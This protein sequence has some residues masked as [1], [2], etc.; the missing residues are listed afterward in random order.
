MTLVIILGVMLTAGMY[1]LADVVSTKVIE[2]HFYNEKNIEERIDGLYG[3]L[4]EYIDQN[5]VKG[6]DTKKL[7]TWTR[8]HKYAFLSIYDD[9]DTVFESGWLDE[10]QSIDDGTAAE[11]TDT[12]EDLELDLSGQVDIPIDE[13]AY[14]AED[15]KNREI[16]FADSEYYV[17]MDDYSENQWYDI[18]RTIQVVLSFLTLLLT[19]LIYSRYLTKRV[20]R[21]SKE[22]EEVSQGNL[23]KQI[24][25]KGKSMDE[26]TSLATGVEDMRRSVLEKLANEQ[27]AWDANCQLITAMSHDIRTPLTSMIGY[28]DIINGKKYESEEEF[29]KYITTCREKAFQLKD[30]SDKLF[31]Y[32][33]VFGNQND[34]I[35]LEPIDANILFDQIL[36]EHMVELMSGGYDVKSE[37]GEIKGNINTEI[38]YMR[39]LFDNLFSNVIKYADKEYP[40][41]VK[42]LS[43]G[44]EVL[45]TITNRISTESKKVESNRIGLK[46]CERICVHLQGKFKYDEQGDDFV[47]TI[48]FPLTKEQIKK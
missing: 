15:I 38:T 29:E 20:I 13:G 27:E 23:Q 19:V 17:F 35:N 30:L 7:I 18:S 16:V 42:A 22:V 44:D 46:T 36:G 21:L 12:S 1:F 26:I 28:L 8:S 5:D 4:E 10:Q 43:K 47:T 31:Q 40:V 33:L 25:M 45:I 39:R 34:E 41:N 2:N 24:V 32:F 11:T 3:D 37:I 6:T 9:T 14:F 48:V